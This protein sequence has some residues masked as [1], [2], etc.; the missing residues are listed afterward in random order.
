RNLQPTR[1]LVKLKLV[2]VAGGETIDITGLLNTQKSTARRLQFTLPTGGPNVDTTYKIVIE[3]GYGPAVIAHE[4]ITILGAGS[5]S[6][7]IG[8]WVP[9][10]GKFDFAANTYNAVT[11]QNNQFDAVLPQ[12]VSTGAADNSAAINANIQYLASKGGAVL[13]FPAGDYWIQ[14]PIQMASNVILKGPGKVRITGNVPGGA[15]R[16]AFYFP[17]G[18]SRS[19]L[20]DILYDNG[21]RFDDYQGYGNMLGQGCTDILLKSCVFDQHE[22]DW[23]QLY[24]G[25][26]IALINNRLNQGI[27]RNSRPYA[28]GPLRLDGSSYVI[29]HGNYFDYCV[30]G[31]NAIGTNH[32]FWS[33]NTFF[34]QASL[35]NREDP[36][37]HVLIHGHSNFWC[38][39]GKNRFTS[40]EAFE[41]TKDMKILKIT[42]KSSNDGE[43]IIAEFTGEVLQRVRACPVLSATPYT[44]SH[45]AMYMPADD[46]YWVTIIAGKGLGQER[47]VKSRTSLGV[48]L[49]EPW[50][51][52]PDATSNIVI[53]VQGVCDYLI[54][55]NDF[56][57][58]KRG[59]TIYLTPSRRGAIIGNR[60]TNAGSIDNT[61]FLQS[62]GLPKQWLF[63]HQWDM[64]VE[65]NIITAETDAHNGNFIG[66]HAVQ[67]R[68]DR[69]V[70]AL[71]L[72]YV[73]RNNK[74]T[75][76]MPNVVA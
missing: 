40:D 67:S 68:Q 51:V 23:L 54:E 6:F 42:G 26:R 36:V 43:K 45:T 47:K 35:G 52:V 17:S 50:D 49:E 21:A 38:V 16:F 29:A 20:V 13:T 64:E 66:I 7:G 62:T 72:G 15:E 48:T 46:H 73:C 18:T 8:Q 41:A 3:N 65:D 2:P 11:K 5:D 30:D 61:P 59:P 74:V 60:M 71:V 63:C 25:R 24:E 9:W 14:N 55:D 22:S 58:G 69:S 19:G 53:G 28:R 32:A 31:V 33:A 75:A 34:W 37:N 39:F 27:N 12:A 1:G 76:R 56:D 10:A 4:T 57:L 44:V 70:G